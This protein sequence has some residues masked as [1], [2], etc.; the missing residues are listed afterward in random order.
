MRIFNQRTAGLLLGLA[1]SIGSVAPAAADDSEI[2]VGAISTVKPNILLI[3]DTSMS[4]GA[5]DI[6][7][8]LE[9]YIPASASGAPTYPNATGCSNT[10]IFFTV[11]L[12]AAE[13]KCDS[14]N[15]I[16]S[17]TTNYETCDKLN[18]GVSGASGRWTGRAA[19]YDS[20]AK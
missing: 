5:D 2:Y 9:P 17:D 12:G 7:D 16:S 18:T 3:L 6:Y 19:Q 20:T 10:K 8:P 1:L 11:G 15:W 4:M 14:P 13:P